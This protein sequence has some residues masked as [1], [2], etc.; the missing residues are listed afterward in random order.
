MESPEFR[1]T[2][3]GV[4]IFDGKLEAD[5]P[6]PRQEWPAEAAARAFLD[7]W[8]DTHDKT[9]R[10]SMDARP[11]RFPIEWDSV[12]TLLPQTQQMRSAARLLALRGRLALYEEDAAATR[13]CID[14]LLG[15][16]AALEQEPVLVSQL[17]SIA[18]DGMA[19]DILKIATERNLL[20]PQD[21]E[22]LI[23]KVLRGTQ[24]GSQWKVAIEGERAMMLPIFSDPQ[25]AQ[26]SLG[27]GSA[28]TLLPFRSR[29]ANHYLDLLDQALAVETEDISRFQI[30]LTALEEKMQEQFSSRNIIGQLDS[31]ITGM[32][33]PAMGAAGGAFTRKTMMHRI[34]VLAMAV[35]LHTF[36]HDCLPASL[37]D[38]NIEGVEPSQL[39]PTGNKPFGYLTNDGTATLWGFDSS[40]GDRTVPTEPPL[41]DLN[42]PYAE[43]KQQWI[44]I[45]EP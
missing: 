23:N 44:W 9:M 33:V 6:S 28:V 40:I 8:R 32:L 17:V 4:P 16:A 18:I 25:I 20:R 30:E 39:M 19:I 1:D 12:N 7:R 22:Y 24:I 21:L 41:I 43:R 35:R 26:A 42:E 11:V 3:E 13:R 45:L 36:Q 29:D 37:D 27:P 38:L 15:C 2:V 34:A 14:A 10:L 31:A 5:F